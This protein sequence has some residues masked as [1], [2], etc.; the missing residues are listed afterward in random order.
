[1][2]RIHSKIIL[3]GYQRLEDLER[4]VWYSPMAIVITMVCL[5]AGANMFWGLSRGIINDPQ[6]LVV[7]YAIFLAAYGALYAYYHAYRFRFLKC[8]GCEQ[9]MKPHIAY[10]DDTSSL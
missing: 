8:P 10:L 2:A 5:G 4:R 7:G 9:V 6:R 1:M 3:S